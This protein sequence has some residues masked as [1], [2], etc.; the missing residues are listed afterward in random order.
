MTAVTVMTDQNV[1]VAIMI[2]PLI[3]IVAFYSTEH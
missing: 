2:Y 3:A 1:P